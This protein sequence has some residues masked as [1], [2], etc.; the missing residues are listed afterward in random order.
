MGGRNP[1]LGMVLLGKD[2]IKKCD[3][4]YQKLRADG[5]GGGA[6]SALGRG[7]GQQVL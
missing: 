7:K 5:E 4:A 3:E 1:T 2:E 6:D